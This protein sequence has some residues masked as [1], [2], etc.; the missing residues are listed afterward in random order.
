MVR[1]VGAGPG[2][3]D[4]ITIRGLE[5]IK[6]ADV[7]IYTG[8]L[9]NTDL[10]N[11]AGKKC[12]CYNSAYMTLPQVIEVMERAEEKGYDTV[13]L[14]TGDPCLYSAVREQMDRLKEKG[15]SYEVCPGVSSFCGSGA[16]LKTEF[17]LP[18][19]SQTVI[20]TRMAGRTPVPDGESIE[21]LSAHQASMVIFL[22]TGMAARLSRELIKGGYSGDTKAA[23][24]YKASWPEEK[25]CRCTV[26]TLAE[27]ADREGI[28]KT[29]LIIVGEALGDDYQLSRLY[30][31]GFSTEFRNKKDGE[32]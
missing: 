24:V 27:T 16:A 26:E 23:I 13:R 9:I 12:K 21:K 3:V 6:K 2:A 10:L 25:V 11:Y 4:L 5:A 31:E 19:I 30:D 20:I 32:P 22:S 28:K 17:T 18:G 7:I 14:H 29:A 1:F 8:S 15:I